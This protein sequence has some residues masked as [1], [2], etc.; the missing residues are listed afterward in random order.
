MSDRKS[1]MFRSTLESSTIIEEEPQY[2]IKDDLREFVQFAFN[3]KVEESF[4]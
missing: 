1:P 3:R 2:Q 4:A